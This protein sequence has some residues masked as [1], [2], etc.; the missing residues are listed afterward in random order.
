MSDIILYCWGFEYLI[1]CS[2]H[3]YC[4]VLTCYS[5]LLVLHILFILGSLPYFFLNQLKQASNSETVVGKLFNACFGYN[6]VIV[7]KQQRTILI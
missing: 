5:I 3:W 7:F 4:T 1:H 6:Y 2:S